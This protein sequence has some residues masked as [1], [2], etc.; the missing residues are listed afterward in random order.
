MNVIGCKLEVLLYGFTPCHVTW[1]R[2]ILKM[3]DKM[4]WMSTSAILFAKWT[5]F[6]YRFGSIL[7][8]T[9]REFDYHIR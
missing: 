8:M 2:R 6:I 5:C 1:D 9:M 3:N 7:G 4:T